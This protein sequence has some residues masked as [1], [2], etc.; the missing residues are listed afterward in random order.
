MTDPIRAIFYTDRDQHRRDAH[1]G[2]VWI[3][4]CLPGEQAALWFY[5]PCGCGL[6]QRI[7][8][9]HRFKPAMHGPSWTWN[10]ETDAITLHPSV[11]IAPNETCAG[12]H[13]W[14]RDGYWEV[15]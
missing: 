3:G 11:N 2:S 8:V 1:P 15:C 9:G 12:W 5:C 6:A 13:G 10:G 4:P 14:L 7:T